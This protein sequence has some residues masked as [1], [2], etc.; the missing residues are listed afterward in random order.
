MPT[1]LLRRLGSGLTAVRA[2]ETTHAT[3]AFR[4]VATWMG[5]GVHFPEAR[6]NGLRN[7]PQIVQGTCPIC[8]C[9]ELVAIGRIGHRHLARCAACGHQ[10]VAACSDELLAAE[11]RAAYYGDASDP[12]IAAWATRHRAVWAAVVGQLSELHPSASAFLDVGSG[13]GGFLE[14]VR[15]RHPRARLAAVESSAAARSALSTRMP[16][17]EFV[18]GDAESLHEATGRFDVVTMLQT[19][20]H[21]FDP[22]AAVRGAV[23]CLN[24]GGLLFATVP[25]RRSLA[26]L[27]HGRSADCFANGTHLQF[28]SHEGLVRL[29]RAGGFERVRRVVHFGGGQHTALFPSAAQYVLRRLGWS[30]ELRLTARSG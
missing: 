25:N 28:F 6:A 29:L 12:R 19:L 23:R 9:A 17:V 7:D 15:L 26:V 1:E 27:L 4:R 18:V 16:D 11:Y 10:F 5:A 20:E 30:T 3:R 2:A 24:P 21:L 8:Q 22:L 13:S 14:Q